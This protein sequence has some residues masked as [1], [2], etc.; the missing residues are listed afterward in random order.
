[1]DPST[2]AFRL[3]LTSSSDH[4]F[5]GLDDHSGTFQWDEMAA[6]HVDLLA[7]N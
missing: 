2:S 1:M 7:P 6:I 3:L 4:V 5:N